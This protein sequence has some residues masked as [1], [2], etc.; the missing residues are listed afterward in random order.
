MTHAFFKALLFLGAGSVIHALSGQQDIFKMGGLRKELPLTF[1]TFTAGWAAILGLPPFSGFFSKDGII[2][3]VW[4]SPHGGGVLAGVLLFS[5]LI[6]AYYMT[7]LY[8]LVFFGASRISK[9]EKEHLHE[10]PLVMTL[11]LMVLA[12]A[13]LAGGWFGAPVKF[14]PAGGIHGGTAGEHGVPESLV[15]AASVLAALAGAAMAR[16]RYAKKVESEPVLDPFRIDS[17]YGMAFGKG[18]PALAG[19]IGRWIEDG[20]VQRLA[21]WTSSLVGLSGNLIRVVQTGSA[22]AY[23]VMIVI[24]MAAF[25]SWLFFG[26]GGYGKF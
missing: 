21:G 5:A 26:V 20:V 19:W 1:W 23:L 10:S 22:Q 17:F 15:M 12:L 8:V 13:S 6:T 24:A 9:K 16:F 7:R 25:L 18:V 3:E 14:S 2:H 4:I 11:P